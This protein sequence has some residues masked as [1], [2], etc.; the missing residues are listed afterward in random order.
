MGSSGSLSC[1]AGEVRSSCAWRGGA[2]HFSPVMVGESSLLFQN[3]PQFIVIHA[4]KRFSVINEADVDVSLEFPC[5]LYHPMNVGNLISG[6]SSFSKTSLNIRKFTVHILLKPGP[7]S[8]H[9]RSSLEDSD[10][11][12]GEHWVDSLTLWELGGQ[13]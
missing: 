3:F 10:H 1:G 4:V 7:V 12:A 9:P 6:S 11:G 13:C 2:R 8:L 5:F